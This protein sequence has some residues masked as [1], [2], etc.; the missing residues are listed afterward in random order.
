M[1][2]IL[3]DE[4]LSSF[5]PFYAQMFMTVSELIY[6]SL[7]L[8][9]FLITQLSPDSCLTNIAKNYSGFLSLSSF[10]VS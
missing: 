3:V 2:R 9:I 7:G 6:A 8:S 5:A 4:F 1:I 10:D